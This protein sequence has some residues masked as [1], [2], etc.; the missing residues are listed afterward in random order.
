M[1]VH[2]NWKFASIRVVTWLGAV[3]AIA[4]VFPALLPGQDTGRAVW[5][6]KLERG[7]KILSEE[8]VEE[9]GNA[10]AMLKLAAMYLDLGYGV[11]G[12][13]SRKI[14]AFKEGARLAKKA[15][16]IRETSAEAHFLY[17][18]N[19]GSAAEIEGLAS[20]ILT[21]QELKRHVVRALELDETHAPAH[22]ML[23]RMFEELPWFLGGDQTAAGHH[24]E[25]AVKLNPLYAPARLDWARWLLKQGQKDEA[26]RELKVVITQPPLEKKWIWEQKYRPEAVLLLRQMFSE[27]ASIPLAP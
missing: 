2:V 13:P 3:V 21:L 5:Q 25:Q 7:I 27:A 1:I 15:L 6:E 11:Y 26:R 18:A 22:H 14:V 10:N 17:A 12:D 24:L 20:S 19:L 9:S 8:K 16:L 23:G 4:W